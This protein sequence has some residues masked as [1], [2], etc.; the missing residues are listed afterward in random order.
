MSDPYIQQLFA[1]RIGGDQYGKSTAIYKFEKIKRAKAAAREA[2]PDTELIDMG[3]GEP[4]EMADPKV[5]DAL[6][7]E[8]SKPENRGYADNGGPEFKEAAARYMQAVFGVE[9]DPV[10]EVVH[11]IGSKSALRILPLCFINP[12]DVAIMTTPG[13]PVLGSHTKY[14]GGEVYN[15]PLT[16]ENNFLPDLDAIPAEVVKRAKVMVLNYPNNPTGA[17]ATADFFQKAIAFAQANDLIL[18]QDAAYASLIFEGRALS[19]LQFPGGKDVAVELHSLSKSFNMTGWRISWVCGNPLIVKAFA[20]MKDNCDSGQFLGI[21]KAAA[22]ALDNPGITERI[23][24][25]YSR[26]MDLLVEVLKEAGFDAAKPQG[27]FFLYTAAPKSAQKEGHTVNFD[28][29]EAFSQF[30]IKELLI[31]TVPWD[32]AGNFVRFSVTFEAGDE[33]DEQ[34][35]IGEI[36]ARLSRYRFSFA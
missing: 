12:G 10:T 24:A 20:D 30:L 3:V 26:R 28:S 34:R 31:S 15:C 4:D 19:L 32:D 14:L 6:C 17:A 5:I 16:A 1:E 9:I 27:S 29:G 25:K 35:V 7:V 11:A 13:Y 22:V 23:S 18:V 36:Q 2:Q 8:A 21:Q 33:A